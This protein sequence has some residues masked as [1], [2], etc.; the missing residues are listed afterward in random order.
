MADAIR[1]AKK[2][3]IYPGDILKI[4]SSWAGELAKESQST[5][6]Y[7][8]EPQK[9][10]GKVV[11]DWTKPRFNKYTPF[12]NAMKQEYRLPM[13]TKYSGTGG[14]ENSEEHTKRRDEIKLEGCK[15]LL[16]FFD[17]QYDEELL[18]KLVKVSSH[19]YHLKNRR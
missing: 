11:T 9:Q 19:E 4:P 14:E 8:P 17:K 10:T 5:V 1:I 15:W 2:A 16:D 3:L 12:F 18:T 7:G 13:K 6:A